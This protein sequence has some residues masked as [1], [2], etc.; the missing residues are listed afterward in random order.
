MNAKELA[1][2]LYGHMLHSHSFGNLL[3]YVMVDGVKREI[4]RAEATDSM[5]VD[6]GGIVF[7]LGDK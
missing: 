2:F 7:V 1:L 6:K 4:I 5:F 3:L